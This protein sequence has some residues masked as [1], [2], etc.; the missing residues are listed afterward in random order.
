MKLTGEGSQVEVILARDSA[1]LDG[2]LVP[3][4]RQVRSGPLTGLEIGGEW[5]PLRAVRAGDRV[6]VWCAGRAREFRETSSRSTSSRGS[7]R[8]DHSAA[9]LSP[10]P[11][12]IRRSLV[13]EGDTVASGQ[14]LLVL[15][16]MKMEHAIRSPRDGRVVRLLFREGE[17]VEA[18]VALVEIE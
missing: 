6:F 16:A 12:R 10:M 15:E 5:I 17:L 14:V 3:F 2:R 1:R 18:G 8:P 4:S 13:A 7:A 9:L 11:G